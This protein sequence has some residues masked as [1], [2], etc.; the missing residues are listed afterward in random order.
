MANGVR[1]I[2]EYRHNPNVNDP[3]AGGAREA[4]DEL[5]TEAQTMADVPYKAQCV[6]P[7]P[8]AFLFVLC[9]AAQELKPWPI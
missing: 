5:K 1:A 3:N 2:H 6:E 4:S 9:S 8:F 7:G